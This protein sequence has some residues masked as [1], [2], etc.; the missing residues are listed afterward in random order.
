MI[1]SARIGIWDSPKSGSIIPPPPSTPRV[2]L[3]YTGTFE[4]A[5]P[6]AGVNPQSFIANE[7]IQSVA[8]ARVG[9]NSVRVT[10]NKTDGDIGG[11][12]R[13]ELN[14]A[15]VSEPPPPIERWYGISFLFP[16]SWAID[17]APEIICQWHEYTGTASPYFALWTQGGHFW[18]VYGGVKA[19]ALD[20]GVYP[21][22]IWTDFVFHMNWSSTISG[23]F[24]MWM[25]GTKMV[26]NR[27]GINTPQYIHAPYWKFGIY[28]WYWKYY[29]TQSQTTQRV[30]YIDECREGGPTSDFY[31]VAPGTY[32]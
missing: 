18:M 21:I 27:V 24:N 15:T 11:S 22:G 6:F 8:Y 13:S 17:T 3:I 7:I 29:P 23:N 28:K 31:S 16:P 26:N 12:K 1:N 10:L 5:N 32:T 20:L 2:G 30:I 19:N 4:G 25:N 9:L 14:R